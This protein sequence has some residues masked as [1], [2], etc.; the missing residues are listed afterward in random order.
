VVRQARAAAEKMHADVF[1]RSRVAE[2]IGK[3]I[4]DLK[5]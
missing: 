5:A 2:D 1:D 4:A 3:F